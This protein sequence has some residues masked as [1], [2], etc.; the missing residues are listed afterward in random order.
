MA[1]LE[2]PLCDPLLE[3]LESW[4]DKALHLLDILKVILLAQLCRTTNAS[5]LSSMQLNSQMSSLRLSKGIHR[6]RLFNRFMIKLQI[7][8]WSKA[9]DIQRSSILIWRRHLLSTTKD[10][11]IGICFTYRLELASF[12]LRRSWKTTTYSVMLGQKSLKHKLTRFKRSRMKTIQ[13]AKGLLS[14]TK[15]ET[16]N[17]KSTGMRY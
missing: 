10:W 14:W 1:P 9:T 6:S 5:T 17:S 3:N 11:A 2:K 12:C 7:T 15:K 8:K 4:E 13:K 16:L